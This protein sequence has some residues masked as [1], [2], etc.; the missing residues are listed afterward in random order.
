MAASTSACTATETRV[1]YLKKAKL[2]PPWHSKSK[3]WGYFG[4]KEQKEFVYCVLCKTKLKY[5]WNT[6]NFLSHFTSQHALEYTRLELSKIKPSPLPSELS[7][8][9]GST[10]GAG[11]RKLCCDPSQ[12]T[13]TNIVL[14]TLGF[15]VYI[16]ETI[17]TQRLAWLHVGLCWVGGGII[18]N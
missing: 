7:A 5:C 10:L 14:Y 18:I 1:D 3:V 4:F 16:F 11:R 6:T 13:T 17:F 8:V 2:V 15:A 9:I 12:T